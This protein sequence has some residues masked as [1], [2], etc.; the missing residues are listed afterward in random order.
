M[1]PVPSTSMLSP[2]PSTSTHTT[3]VSAVS[4]CGM[5]YVRAMHFLC[6]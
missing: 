5:K 1:S 4:T 6:L 2:V 3:D